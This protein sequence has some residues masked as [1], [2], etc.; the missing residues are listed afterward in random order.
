MVKTTGLETLDID[1]KNEAYSL[2]GSKINLTHLND[3]GDCVH[4]ALDKYGLAMKAI[5]Y[6][7]G[8]DSI[9][10]QIKK[11]IL[12]IKVDLSHTGMDIDVI[13]DEL[14]DIRL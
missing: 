2:S 3:Q 11:G 5:N 7:A 8:G 4:D 10:I 1:C 13:F 14:D 6:N 9:E 12:T